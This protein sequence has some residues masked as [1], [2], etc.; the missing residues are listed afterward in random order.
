MRSI[1]VAI[2]SPSPWAMAA[3]TSA[4]NIP[5]KCLGENALCFTLSCQT[6][7]ARPR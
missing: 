1:G 5:H 3:H 6:A 7:L 2:C 4:V